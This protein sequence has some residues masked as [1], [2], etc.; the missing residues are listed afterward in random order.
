MQLITEELISELL[1][2][3]EQS[4]RRRINYNFH[5]SLDDT[6]HRFLNV[7]LRGTFVA[8][9]RHTHPP[10][11][12]SFV[13]L[14]GNIAFIIFNDDGSIQESHILG[15]PVGEKKFP[16]GIDILPGT[17]HT[18]IVLGESAVIYEVKPGPYEPASD[19]EFAEW[20]PKEGDAKCLEIQ[21]EWIQHARAQVGLR[22]NEL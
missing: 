3:A 12:E 2:K 15:E 6:M 5:R 9:H 13:V 14:R 1:S 8:A 16:V 21:K 10:K 18:L 17:W 19:K 20:S 22:D 11:D 4:P 7:M